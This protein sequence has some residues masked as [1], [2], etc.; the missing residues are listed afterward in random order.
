MDKETAR[1]RVAELTKT[2]EY[3]NNL[4]YNQDDPEISDFEYDMLLRRT[5]L[6]ADLS[7]TALTGDGPVYTAES[8]AVL[9]RRLNDACIVAPLAFSKSEVWT[10]ID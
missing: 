4:Y 7:L 3:H 1:L 9:Q 8:F 10:H 6:P 5:N 2:I